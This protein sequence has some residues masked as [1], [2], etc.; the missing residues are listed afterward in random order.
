MLREFT[1]GHAADS[2][3]PIEQN[4]PRTGGTLVER[5]DEL[6]HN[7]SVMSARLQ[8]SGASGKRD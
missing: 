1:L 4:C 6:F 7:F 5:E 3:G 2:A 8:K